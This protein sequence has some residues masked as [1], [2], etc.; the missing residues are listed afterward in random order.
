MADHALSAPGHHPKLRHHFVSLK[1]QNESAQLGMWLFLLTEIMFFGGLFGGY[2]VYRWQYPQAW[3]DASHHLDILLGG[4]N[5]VVLI[6]SSLTMVL[7]VQGAEKGRKGLI[8]GWLL[9]TIALGSVFLVVKYFE[10]ADKFTHHLVPGYNFHVEAANAA[11][12]QLF[13]LFY[14][15]M[16]GMHALHMIIGIAALAVL[17]RFAARGVFDEKY[18]PHVELVGLY[19]HFVDIVWIFLFPLL[20]LI[21]RH[22]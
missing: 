7:A 3:A 21:G 13:Y 14:F 9:A 18:Y 1:Q 17:V 10:Y 8:I 20:Y 4:F 19:W 11:Q 12:Q 5:T 2:A 22:V 15:A 16:T 6:G